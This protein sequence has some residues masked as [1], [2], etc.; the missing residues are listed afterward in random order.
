MAARPKPSPGGRWPRRGRCPHRPVG[1]ACAF[2]VGA[3]PRGRPLFQVT[4]WY[5]GIS[6]AGGTSSSRTTYPSLCPSVGR[7]RS[8]RR[9]SSPNR[10]RRAGLRFGT[11]CGRGWR[12]SPCGASFFLSDEKETKWPRPPSLAPS[13]QFTLE[14]PGAAHGHLTMPYPA[15]PYPLCPFGTS[16]PDRGRRPRT[17]V[18]FYGGR[19]QE[20]RQNSSG[21]G[22]GQDTCLSAARCAAVCG[23]AALRM[24]R[25][26][27]GCCRSVFLE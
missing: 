14:S 11:A 8:F 26:P 4:N 23:F 22:K 20:G 7:T 16:P 25:T 6:P 9:S 5:V 1:L 12:I 27:C 18:L 19:H 13:G 3:A 24:R 2:S 10:T 21:A 15:G 17:P